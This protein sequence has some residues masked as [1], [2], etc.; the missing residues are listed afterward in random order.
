V[1]PAAPFAPKPGTRPPFSAER[2]RSHVRLVVLNHVSLD[3]VMQ[4]P[5]RPDEDTRAGFAHGGWATANNDEVMG[6]ALGARMGRT[7]GALLLGRRTYADRLSFW[8]Q[9]GGPFA[10]ALNRATKY[11]ASS[12]AATRLEWPNS[13]RLHGD[14][15]AAVRELKLNPRQV[16]ARVLGVEV[17]LRPACWP[18]PA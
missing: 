4:A 3:G 9:A 6:S 15:P 12:G 18:R 8:N 2:Q 10:D 7:E 5:G 16:R 1:P 11:V 14:V 17:S 13:T